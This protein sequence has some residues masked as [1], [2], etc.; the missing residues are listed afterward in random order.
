MEA[1]H[2]HQSGASL[3][4]SGEFHKLLPQDRFTNVS[5]LLYQNIAPVVDPIAQQLTPGQLQG[6]KAIAAETKPS[7]VCAYG[8]ESAIRLASTT[9]YFGLDLNSVALSTLSFL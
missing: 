7:V 4:K 2:T 6:L 3:A 1:I 5:A 9:K 8:E